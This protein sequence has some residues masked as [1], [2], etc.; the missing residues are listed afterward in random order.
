MV[1]NFWFIACGPC[2]MEVTPLNEVV[3]QFKGK[4]VVF[5]SVASDKET[6]LVKHL[7]TMPFSFR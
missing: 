6:D 1:L 4:G 7:Q 2:R 5:L 3:K